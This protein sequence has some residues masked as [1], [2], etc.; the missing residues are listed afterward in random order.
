MDPMLAIGALF[1]VVVLV[2]L[3]L[4]SRKQARG[5]DGNAWVDGGSASSDGP[6]D[7]GSDAGGCDGGGDG[8]GGGD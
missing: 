6:C 4:A 7:G 2:V 8:G 3:V 1:A 5:G